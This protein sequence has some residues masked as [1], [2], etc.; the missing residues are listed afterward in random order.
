MGWLQDIWHRSAAARRPCTARAQRAPLP[1]RE[2]LD[3]IIEGT[4]VGTWEWDVV[5]GEMLVN[6]RFGLILGCTLAELEPITIDTWVQVAHAEDWQRATALLHAHFQGRSARF[7]C[8]IRVRTNT[9]RWVWV[10]NR[11]RV[12]SRAADGR[13]LSMAGTVMDIDARKQAEER[14]RE[15]EAFSLSILN[16]VTAEIAVLDPDG[17]I[18]AV[19][20]PWRKF[21]L[22]NGLTPGEAAPRTDIGVNYLSMCQPG[23]DSAEYEDA[24]QTRA[25]ILAVL[26]G[27]VSAFNLEYP[28]DSAT[29]RR[30]FA[31][32]VTPLGTQ[33]LGVVISHTNIT[34]RKQSEAET[35]R[36]RLELEA[37]NEQ[38][39]MHRQVL[40]AVSEPILVKGAGSKIIWAN[41]VFQ[42]YYGMNNDQL[43]A[44]IDAPFVPADRTLQYVRDDAQ[45]FASGVA[46]DIPDEA[47]VRFDGVVQRWHTV[48]SPIFDSAGQVV[49]TVGVSRDMTERHQADAALRASQALL[50]KT[51]RIAGVGG[52]TLDLDTHVTVWTDQTCRIHEVEPGHRPTIEEGIRYY[53]PEARPLIELALLNSIATGEGFDLE[54][55]FITAKGR[56][57]WVRAVGEPEIVAGRAVRL[58]GAF[59][60]ITARR[61]L[62]AEVQ[63]SA[64]LLRG[65]ID[66]I[67]E[68]FVLFDPDDRLVYCNDKYR[69]MY[70]G[71]AARIVPGAR[72][73]DILRHAALHGQ[74]PDAAGRVDDWVAERMA[75]H[76]SGFATLEQRLADGRTLRVVDR[77]TPDGHIV[78]S[79]ID[80]SELV[81]ATEAAQ[82][83]SQAKSEFVANMSH[84]IR[85]PMN[86]ILGMLALLRRT[87]L[88]PRQADYAGKTE[89]AARSL[90]GLLGDILD[91]SKVEAGKMTLDPQPFRVAALQHTLALIVAAQVGDKPVALRFE[92]DPGLPPVLV[93]DTMR[94]QQVLVNLGGNAV[95]FTDA[96]EVVVSMV[97]LSRGAAAVEVAF[98]VRDTGIGIA[99]E[100]QDRIF[101]GFTQAEA[102]TTRRFGGTGLGLAISRRLVALMGGDL[103][104]DSALGQGSRF[105]FRITLPVAAPGAEPSAEAGT[106]DR[107]RGAAGSPR[108][109]GMRVLVAEDNTNNQQVA[110]ELLEDEGAIVQI[111]PDGQAALAAVAAAV[112]PFD[113][114]LMDLQMPVMDGCT[115][116]RRMRQDLGLHALPIIAMTANAMASDR[117]ACLAAGMNDHV[118]KPFEIDPLV[119][120]L[121]R[122]AGWAE[123]PAA[124]HG[125]GLSAAAVAT[126]PPALALDIARAAGAAGV[127]LDA[128]LKRLGGKQP[129]YQRMLHTFVLDLAAM[130]AQLQAHL[131]EGRPLAATQL[132]HTL[133]GLAATIGAGALADQA[134]RAE[135]QLGAATAPEDSVVAAAGVCAAIAAAGPG[136][137][138]L[139]QTLQAA[140]KPGP[141]E[142]PAL[143]N[144]HLQTALQALAGQLR[145][146][147]MAAT[148]TME[149]LQRRFGA[150]LGQRLQ[151]LDDAIG[152]LDFERALRLCVQLMAVPGDTLPGQSLG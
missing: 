133:K 57:I 2:R 88:T 48:K 67:E 84:E 42:A 61:A 33:G 114:V 59:Q 132:L 52:W 46:L 15:S 49:A 111:A 137:A 148:D 22:D 4:N 39:L 73:E 66:A 24:A 97:L 106:A 109:A 21:A 131:A 135:R 5:S 13:P 144:T 79:R 60:D 40:D 26:D 112:P 91:F 82:A 126:R 108:L 120:L 140:Q 38:L 80:I 87:E 56:A 99:P 29:E 118:G 34:E 41:R 100:N 27:S 11:G 45:V 78:G 65:A 116:A 71:A 23:A 47:I 51:G 68:G 8:E 62:E 63:R 142:T 141:A 55:P 125:L 85:T 17:V 31:L 115:A 81:R 138:L 30:W 139:L 43:H 37:Q 104:L 121:R 150:A 50:D 36:Q 149:A 19:N 16:S 152:A 64:G 44:L 96:G 92:I 58:V 86:A 72:F 130:P 113:A 146:A 134:A 127:D 93:G 136:L 20:E 128:A 101:S 124:P 102:S 35:H 76:R 151:A 129:I 1:D 145:Q 143:D 105:H 10:L 12:F 54:L 103:Q 74:H 7:E 90:L 95:K 89:G 3:N 77:S 18:V 70:A 110:R 69:Q 9:G 83:A 98:A 28:C 122:H 25:G 117:E 6:E 147:D 75:T 53:A 123:A 107:P 94:L 14:L 119:Q 32:S